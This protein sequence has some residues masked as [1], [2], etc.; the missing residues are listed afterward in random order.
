MEISDNMNSC[1]TS[2]QTGLAGYWQFNE[3]RGS[4]VYDLAGAHDLTLGNFNFNETDGWM[5]SNAPLPVELTSFTASSKRLNAEL[6]WSTATEVNNAGFEVERKLVSRPGGQ[7]GFTSQV[8]GEIPSSLKLETSNSDWTRI[9]F[10]D[11]AGSSNTAHEYS[12][13]DRSISAGTYAFRL[14]QIDRDGRFS[15]S[16]TVEVT[17]SV[18]YIFSLEQ[19]FP[20]PFNPSTS[21]E[22]Q[23]PAAGKV[24]LSVF[25]ALGREIAEL[26]NE[27]KD[28]GR[29]SVRF[30]GTQRP[31][32]IYFARLS[33]GGKTSVKKMLLV[34]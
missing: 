21:I 9:A 2:S 12:Y 6:K 30:D 5:D 4:T 32:G 28:A 26:V 19:N 13:T 23:L 18:P 20:N 22:Y 15:Y 24:T 3:N 29:Y 33:S 11:G 14:K 7:A 8:S 1:F 34:K 10:V 31:S 16:P 27:V 25:D 17:T